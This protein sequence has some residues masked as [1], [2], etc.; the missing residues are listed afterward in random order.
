[1]QR[2]YVEMR[3][4]AYYLAGSRVSLASI[5]Y[6]HRDGATAETIRENFPTLSLE[7]IEGAIAYYLGHREAAETYLRD[8]ERKWEELERAAKPADTELQRRIEEV[9]KRS[10]HES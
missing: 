7:Q 10:G 3:N 9:K 1:M 2:E 8:L 4:G 5:I 6:E